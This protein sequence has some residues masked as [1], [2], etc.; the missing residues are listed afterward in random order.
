MRRKNFKIA[1]NN[2]SVIWFT[3][4]YLNCFSTHSQQPRVVV[5]VP[6]SGFSYMSKL[7]FFNI[8]RYNNLFLSSK[9]PL[10]L[11]YCLQHIFFIDY[12]PL[13]FEID[14]I[15]QN[16][17][18]VHLEKGIVVWTCR[19]TQLWAFK[20]MSFFSISQFSSMAFVFTRIIYY[21]LLINWASWI[22]SAI[23]GLII[24][25]SWLHQKH[26]LSSPVR[27]C[28]WLTVVTSMWPPV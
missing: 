10:V 28:C 21:S 15:A 12:K 11:K 23:Q 4:L 9:P 7:I 2:I 26:M 3:R 24:S 6:H 16:L 5:W 1:C 27:K 25:Q 22:I 14:E 8:E 20:T 17:C 18:L 19:L 13:Y